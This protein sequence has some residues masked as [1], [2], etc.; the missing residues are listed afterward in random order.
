MII[1]W[2][3]F[4]DLKDRDS[5]YIA[6]FELSSDGKEF[7]KSALLVAS[8]RGHR[9]RRIAEMRIPGG[10]CV[11]GITLSYQCLNMH[12]YMHSQLFCTTGN[13]FSRIFLV[14]FSFWK[15]DATVKNSFFTIDERNDE[16]NLSRLI[17][18]RKC[19]NNEKVWEG[20]DQRSI[21]II[22]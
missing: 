11:F 21:K 18:Y 10:R 13:P 20:N 1:W 8:R 17:F 22:H 4:C 19:R 6:D 9:D 15:L 12:L 16:V 2:F 5:S 7:S 14:F 3:N